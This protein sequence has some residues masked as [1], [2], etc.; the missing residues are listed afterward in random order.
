MANWEKLNMEFED[1]LNSMTDKKWTEFKNYIDKKRAEKPALN[2]QNVSK[3]FY[4]QREIEGESICNKQCDHCK[5]YYAPL[6][7]Q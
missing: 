1:T 7:R 4:C 3:S 5:E 2:L 6:E